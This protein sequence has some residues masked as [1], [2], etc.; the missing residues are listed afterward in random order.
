MDT[1]EV[2]TLKKGLLILDVLRNGHSLTMSEIMR[3]LSLNK[4]SAFRMLHTLKKM[5]YVVKTDKYYQLNPRIF[6]DERIDWHKGVQWTSIAAPYHLARDVGETVYIGILDQYELVMKN[7]I[8]EPFIEPF[9]T[10][11]DKRTPIHSSALGKVILAHLSKEKQREILNCVSLDDLTE[12]TFIDKQLFIPHLHVIQTQGYAVDAEE[13]DIGKWCI[14]APVYLHNEVIGAIAV[15][16][17]VDRIKKKSVRSL[18]KKIK[19]A[20]KQLTVE[21]EN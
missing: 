2:T 11:I 17:P 7:V 12:N 8:K 20:S 5:N 6:R 9:F 16:G 14:A 15:H 21:L 18:A 10:A 13:T 4:T 3:E 19:T 1:Y